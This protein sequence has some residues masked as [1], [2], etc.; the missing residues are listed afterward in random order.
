MTS[1]IYT[2]LMLSRIWSI[3]SWLILILIFHIHSIWCQTL[4]RWP[5]FTSPPNGWAYAGS[6]TYLT[7]EQI[8]ILRIYGGVTNTDLNIT[9]NAMYEL[10]L[11]N[12]RL[13]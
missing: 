9:S 2:S 6:T 7:S 13:D 10:N 1:V 8:P 11:Y 4:Y 5:S 12:M 3:F